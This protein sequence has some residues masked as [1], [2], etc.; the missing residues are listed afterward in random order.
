MKNPLTC[1]KEDKQNKML[2]KKD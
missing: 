2:N 1:N